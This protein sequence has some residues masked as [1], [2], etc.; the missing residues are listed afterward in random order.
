MPG[1]CRAK[2][3]PNAGTPEHLALL[4]GLCHIRYMFGSNNA[5]SADNQQERLA[6]SHWITG[7]VDGEGCFSVG[8][9]KQP[10]RGKRKGYKLGIQVW[11]EFAVT[12][13]EKSIAVLEELKNFFRVGDIYINKR[14]DNHK[15]HMH[16]YT[17]RRREELRTVIIPFFQSFP[18]HTAKKEDFCKFVLCFNLI[19]E[20]KHLTVEG[21]HEICSLVSTM[22]RQKDRSQVLA[23]IL[24]DHTRGPNL[25]SS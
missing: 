21:L 17:V 14:Y 7:F 4:I 11:C 5:P 10:N 16:R 18:L 8:F 12:Q 20:G 9:I 2:T 19:E 25:I 1:R 3:T 15:E 6:I 24:N 22:N 13:G 23:G